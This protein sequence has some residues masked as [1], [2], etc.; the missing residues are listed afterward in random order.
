[1]LC[2]VADNMFHVSVHDQ[3]AVLPCRL[4]GS[5]PLHP[6]AIPSR[7]LHRVPKLAAPPLPASNTPNSVCSSWIP[8]KYHT[9]H[10]VTLLTVTPI[11]TYALYHV[12]SV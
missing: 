12:S 8:T 3:Q 11:V 4:I 9:L 5:N 2:T 10:Y 1:V 6:S 7:I